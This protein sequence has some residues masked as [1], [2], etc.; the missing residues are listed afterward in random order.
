TATV[1]HEALTRS[2]SALSVAD[3][4]EAMSN[5]QLEVWYQPKVSLRP[6]DRDRIVGAEALIRWRHPERGVLIA[7][8]FIDLIESAGLMGSLSSC[9]LTQVVRD[10][11][12]WSGLPSKFA[13]GVN[14]P[15]SMISEINFPDHFADML[16]NGGISPSNIIIEV[17]ER[18]AI[19]DHTVATDS[20]TRLRLK[21]I[22][23]S[24]DDFGLGH[25]SLAELYRMPFSEVKIDA[26]F[27]R[28]LT[29]FPDARKIIKSV[30]DLSREL[31]IDCCAE[32]IETQVQA[33]ALKALGCSKGQGHLFGR[34]VPSRHFEA[35]LGVD[36]GAANQNAR[37]RG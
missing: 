16:A 3:L 26:S 6:N 18:E 9:V 24:M 13:V 4:R 7:D 34:A 36:T 23:L 28:D 29:L 31:G 35:L 14:L 20:M 15:A 27:I 10:L 19:T 33:I 8:S 5:G 22:G 12:Q 32:G 30:I 2:R 37:Q 1:L 21:G 17:T 25:S 11:G